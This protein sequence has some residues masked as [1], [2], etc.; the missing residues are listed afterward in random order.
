MKYHDQDYVLLLRLPTAHLHRVHSQCSLRACASLELKQNH[1]CK[2]VY[3]SPEYHYSHF[4]GEKT[5]AWS[6][7]FCPWSRKEST[8][9]L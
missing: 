2:A 4:T 5:E 1:A 8:A 6:G 7:K 9:L 3:G